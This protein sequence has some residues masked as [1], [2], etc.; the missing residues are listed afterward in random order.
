MV[1]QLGLLGIL[2]HQSRNLSKTYMS[3]FQ[4][5]EALPPSLLPLIQYQAYLMHLRFIHTSY[6]LISF[7]DVVELSL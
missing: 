2:I 5:Q 6:P 7:Y 1:I 4:V 3:F